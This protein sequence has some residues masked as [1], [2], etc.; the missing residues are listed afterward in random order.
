MICI[1]IGLSL[2]IVLFL[3]SACV[4]AGLCSREEEND[5]SNEK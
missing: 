3:W 4:V 1:F 2:L 5:L